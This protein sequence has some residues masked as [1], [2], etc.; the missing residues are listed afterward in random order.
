MAVN[1]FN[2]CVAVVVVATIVG[3]AAGMRRAS[4]AATH[5]P[6]LAAMA[7]HAVLLCAFLVVILALRQSWAPVVLAALVVVVPPGVYHVLRARL[8]GEG[9][10]ADDACDAT[11][12][13]AWPQLSD[14]P[15]IE[16]SRS[17]ALRP[18]PVPAEEGEDGGGEDGAAYAP[19]PADAPASQPV[20][21]VREQ[22]QIRGES[23]RRFAPR[24]AVGESFPAF[25]SIQAQ[26]ATQAL[27]KPEPVA[28]DDEPLR[29]V[30]VAA[31][32]E[33]IKPVLVEADEELPESVSVEQDEEP[34]SP[35]LTEADEEAL[36]PILAKGEDEAAQVEAV[37]AEGE[38][39]R[40]VP[41]QGGAELPRPV[42]VEVGK[43][44]PEPACA[45][46]N[47]EPLCPV[48]VEATGEL[49]RPVPVRV[50]DVAAAPEPVV[51]PEPVA[52]PESVDEKAPSSQPVATDKDVDA[53]K[54]GAR[55]KAVVALPTPRDPNIPHA[56]DTA[57]DCKVRAFQRARRRE[58]EQEEAAEAQA[59]ARAAEKAQVRAAEEAQTRATAEARI[60][61]ME[62]AAALQ[63]APVPAG[64]PQ[65][66]P[67]L[68]SFEPDEI[69][70]G[71]DVD[72]MLD[73]DFA[74]D[75]DVDDD[76]P[77]L[78]QT[79]TVAFEA[80]DAL[81]YEFAPAPEPADGAAAMPAQ[82]FHPLDIPPAPAPAANSGAA[83]T[84]ELLEPASPAVPEPDDSS[85]PSAEEEALA[86][87]KFESNRRKAQGFRDRGKNL[88]AAGLFA[89]AA[90]LAPERQQWREMLFEE[91]GCYVRADKMDEARELAR[92]LLAQGTLTRA[93]RIK[94]N[95]IISKK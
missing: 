60:H 36:E 4:D 93:N 58:R 77:P 24:R 1:A 70:Y 16:R 88:V 10:E 13:V 80:P 35:V 67:A 50:E 7:A 43:D 64:Q 83:F 59:R 9:E 21:Q 90:D 27:L 39:L 38:V 66:A 44:V 84:V 71:E 8:K 37:Q 82:G 22:R 25:G 78:E 52:A 79:V 85:A 54:A 87:E 26:Q 61:A 86:W 94:L 72:A 19:V 57:A 55:E 30:P 49:L 15:Q 68:P 53:A 75:D 20:F 18:V 12:G 23:A 3:I 41:V 28:A 74:L 14:S 31:E 6:A 89:R 11:S 33:P 56:D 69:F 45:E 95:A 46:V 76:L 51:A 40:P 2:V 81:Q 34:L 42:P 63:P 62:E 48:P 29:P 32:V 92:I 47:E 65:E 91:L 73:D 5:R 17:S